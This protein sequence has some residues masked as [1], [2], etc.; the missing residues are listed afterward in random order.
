MMCTADWNPVCG[1]DGKTYSNTCKLQIGQCKDSTLQLDHEGE[2]TDTI[3]PD[4]N[5]ATV[6]TD[7]VAEAT[8]KLPGACMSQDGSGMSCSSSCPNMKNMGRRFIR[9]VF[10]GT[11]NTTVIN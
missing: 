11:G 7:V 2:C 1:N 6:S 10:F 3:K 9:R 5:D 4:D 8:N